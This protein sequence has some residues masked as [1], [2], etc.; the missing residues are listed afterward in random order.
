[1]SEDT[2][3]KK[4]SMNS[5]PPVVPIAVVPPESSKVVLA[6]EQLAYAKL[7]NLGMR[8]GLLILVVSFLV[9]M[10][11]IMP[12]HTPVGDLP[13]YWA[14]PVKQYLEV[15]GIH[16]GWGWLAMLDKGDFVNFIGIA[17]LSGV[18]LVCYL[19]IIPI[20]MRRKETVYASIAVLEVLVLALAA[21]GVLRGGGH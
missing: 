15:T 3:A 21:S 8:V 14:M 18:T 5:D 1:M 11:G 7:L 20:F 13:R 19:S 9:Y 4:L 16:P 12:P 6:E 2:R 17:F 10:L